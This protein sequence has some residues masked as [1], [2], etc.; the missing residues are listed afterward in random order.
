M[1]KILRDIF[2]SHSLLSYQISTRDRNVIQRDV[3]RT[4]TGIKLCFHFS[5]FQA[6]EV[7]RHKEEG[8]SLAYRECSFGEW[9]KEMA[10]GGVEGGK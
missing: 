5:N 6:W 7:T 10:K 3:R 8:H 4:M 1:I 2:E 9:W